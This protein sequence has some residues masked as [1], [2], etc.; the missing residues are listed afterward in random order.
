MTATQQTSERILGYLARLGNEPKAT[1]W[2]PGSLAT[3]KAM[4]PP[5][6]PQPRGFLAS[7]PL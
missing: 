5:P 4:A 1:P 3:V 6:A 2:A 7:E